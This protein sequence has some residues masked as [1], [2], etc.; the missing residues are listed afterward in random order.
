MDA[1]LYPHSASVVCMLAAH[2]VQNV[3]LACNTIQ[4]R[5]MF[6]SFCVNGYE[7]GILSACYMPS[8]NGALLFR[9]VCIADTWSLRSQ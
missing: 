3:S 7:L 8:Q 5:L 6:G 1:Y 2:A 9:L 4:T